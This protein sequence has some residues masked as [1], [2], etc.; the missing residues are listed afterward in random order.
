[1]FG[2]LIAVQNL[3]NGTTVPKIMSISYGEC[4]ARTASSANASYVS[5]YEQAAAEGVSVFVSA[6]DE[7]AASCD[8]DEDYATHGIAVSGFASTP[9]N[10]AVGGTDFMDDYDSADRRPGALHVLERDQRLH[11]RLGALV[12]P[13]DPVERLVRQ[14]AHLRPRGVRR[15]LRKHRLLLQQRRETRTS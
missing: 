14:Q 12:H 8:A 2:G 15:G 10:V 11:V 1:M 7:G 5:T 13:R 3:I 4:E 6:G 9:Y